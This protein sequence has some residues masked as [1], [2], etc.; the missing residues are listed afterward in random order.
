MDETKTV[1]L[2]CIFCHST[3]F[4]LLSED[5]VPSA[6]EHI[7]CANCEKLNIYADIKAIAI[8]KSK[9]EI[10]KEVKKLIEKSFKNI[11]LKL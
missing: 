11:T 3:N 9:K 10:E 5:Y 8:E 2:E 4:E 1:K 7:K 6:N